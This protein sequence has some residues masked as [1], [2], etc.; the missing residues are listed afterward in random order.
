MLWFKF[1]CSKT[2]NIVHQFVWK[3]C[4]MKWSIIVLIWKLNISV[5]FVFIF[6]EQYLLLMCKI[7]LQENVILYYIKQLTTFWIEA[8][9]L[10]WS[11]ADVLIELLTTSVYVYPCGKIPYRASLTSI[12]CPKF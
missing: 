6:L 4:V 9:L 10:I 11:K 1:Y 3:Y 8:R 5:F 7:T 12:S 2:E